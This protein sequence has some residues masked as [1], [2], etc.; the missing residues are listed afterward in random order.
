MSR[1]PS[2][3]TKL[4][5]SLVRAAP[6][7]PAN[8]FARSLSLG[9]RTDLL[10]LGGAYG[11]HVV[12]EA[13]LGSGA[14]CYS[15]GVGNDLSF[16][17]AL[18]ERYGCRVHAFDPTP[19]AQDFVEGLE[20][21]AELDFRPFGLW[22]EDTYLD[23]WDQPG[24][25]GAPAS[26]YSATDL[27]GGGRQLRAEVKSLRSVMSSLGHEQ[28]D[29]LKLDIEGAEYEVIRSILTDEIPVNV[30]TVEFH[31]NPSTQSMRSAVADLR[32]ARL[33]PEHVDGYEV[34]FVRS[35]LLPPSRASG[36]A[37][38]RVRSQLRRR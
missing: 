6:I 9:S 30:L 5:R 8:R 11:G 37:P 25:R 33:F 17:L 4:W 21:P 19:A 15:A 34:A 3:S 29:L 31:K 20:L 27:Y 12:A 16:D 24:E 22:S 38:G 2:H 36:C 18:I 1:S 26:N 14:V 35:P 32:R 28:I 10:R 23:F 13:P 7:S